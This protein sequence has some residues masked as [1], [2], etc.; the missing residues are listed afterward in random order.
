[1]EKFL[2]KINLKVLS[3]YMI[4]NKNFKN[5]EKLTIKKILKIKNKIKKT[6]V[7]IFKSNKVYRNAYKNH[8]LDYFYKWKYIIYRAEN[9]LIY[10]NLVLFNNLKNHIINLKRVTNI[11]FKYNDKKN[12]SGFILNDHK[13][14]F[15][16]FLIHKNRFTNK[17]RLSEFWKLI[18]IFF[19]DKLN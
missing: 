13:K 6:N 4:L 19:N 10:K 17:E 7:L 3:L 14:K 8:F 5:L 1:M 18:D 9:F 2:K 15:Y 11:Y 12:I 16:S